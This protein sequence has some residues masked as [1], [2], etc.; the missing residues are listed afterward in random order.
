MESRIVRFADLC[1]DDPELHQVVIDVLKSGQF[2]FGNWVEKFS[3]RWAEYCNAKYC[4]PCASGS[5]ALTAALKATK[6][7]KNALVVVPAMSFA[8]TTF[9]VYEAGYKPIYVDV[10][11]QG[12]LNLDLAIEAI[13]ATGARAVLPVHL[14]GRV[15]DLEALKQYDVMVIEDA[16]QAHGAIDK[17]QSLAAGFSF[18]P[19]KNLG[20]CGDA[21]AIITNFEEVADYCWQYISYGDRKG[22]KYDHQI[23]GTNARMDNIQAAILCHKLPNLVADNNRRALNAMDYSIQ[24]GIESICGKV[25]G[26]SWVVHQYPILAEDPVELGKALKARGIDTGVH[27]PYTL[28][29]IDSMG[30]VYKDIPVANY[31]AKHLLSLPVAQHLG[32]DDIQ[33]VAYVLKEE[34]FLNPNGEWELSKY[35]V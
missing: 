30:I 14:F 15:M 5:A 26:N 4:I 25:W 1:H 10:D 21:G 2:I 9:S 35:G 32:R 24:W 33:Y 23:R 28:P 34:A 11:K 7:P 12:L 18:Y 31:L 29:G 13:K 22:K 17:M 16:C 27:Y 6:L 20:A 19:A 3:I 8:A